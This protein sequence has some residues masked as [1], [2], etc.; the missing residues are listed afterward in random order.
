YASSH[1]VA[2][3]LHDRVDA[4][5]WVLATPKFAR[6]LTFLSHRNVAGPHEPVDIDPGRQPVFILQPIDDLVQQRLDELQI[7]VGAQVG[8]EI[9]SKFDPEPWRLRKAES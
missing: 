9:Q 7:R 5:G 2:K 8:P 1:E 3:L 4:Q 6:I